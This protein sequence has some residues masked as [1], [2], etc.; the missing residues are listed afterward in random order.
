LSNKLEQA[1]IRNTDN[2]TAQVEMS[3]SD[4]SH[5]T[6][7]EH[8]RLAHQ[9]TDG[10]LEISISRSVARQFYTMTPVAEINTKTGQSELLAKLV[11]WLGLLFTPLLFTL[12][13]LLIIYYYG[14][15]AAVSIPFA[16]ILWSVIAGFLNPTG[17]WISMT[18][19][20]VF[21]VAVTLANLVT[22]SLTFPL[23]AWTASLWVNRM[24]YHCAAFFLTRLVVKSHIA[25]ELLE[26]HV[27]INKIA[28]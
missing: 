17:S 24:T 9:I 3:L 28:A 7:E 1:T 23:L 25:F 27:S 26:E 16:G 5:L 4:L 21:I 6:S 12:S 20:L 8:A 11:V 10:T 22:P 13:A 18:I 19:I 14:W 15:W 2:N